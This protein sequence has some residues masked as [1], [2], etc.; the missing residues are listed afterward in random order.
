M[1]SILFDF[2]DFPNIQIISSLK[3]II[4]YY[5]YCLG[6]RKQIY[7]DNQKRAYNSIII[8]I[9]FRRWPMW[10]TEKQ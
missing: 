4:F 7:F 3:F 10:T 8:Q 6:C 2:S 1:R 9:A 5:Q